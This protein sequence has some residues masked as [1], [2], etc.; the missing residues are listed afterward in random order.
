MEIDK[1]KNEYLTKLDQQKEKF[2]KFVKIGYQKNYNFEL[3]LIINSLV[4][5][6][7]EEKPNQDTQS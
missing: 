3:T 4:R 6:R 1:I 7:D 5:Q 2:R